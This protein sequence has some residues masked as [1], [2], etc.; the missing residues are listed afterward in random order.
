MNTE[1]LQ[2]LID[3]FKFLLEREKIKHDQYE[4]IRRSLVE[5]LNKGEN[6]MNEL[7]ALLLEMQGALATLNSNQQESA[8]DIDRI[9]QSL[10]TEGGISAAEVAE[11][12]SSLTSTRDAFVA[13]V[14]KSREVADKIPPAVA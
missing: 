1:Q 5:I 3:F 10:P 12:K 4:T 7:R 8:D 14:A 2:I 9:L 6:N 11:L 13:A